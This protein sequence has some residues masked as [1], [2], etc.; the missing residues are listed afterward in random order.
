M[1]LLSTKRSEP[2]DGILEELVKVFYMHPPRLPQ[3]V[4]PF[5]KP[6]GHCL[7]HIE[8]PEGEIVGNKV[9]GSKIGVPI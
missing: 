2:I 1:R 8:L 6:T 3:F 9:V 5:K 7:Q 4:F